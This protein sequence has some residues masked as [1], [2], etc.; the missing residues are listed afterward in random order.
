MKLSKKSYSKVASFAFA[1]L[2]TQMIKETLIKQLELMF[3]ITYHF[4][5]FLKNMI[6][7]TNKVTFWKQGSSFSCLFVSFLLASTFLLYIGYYFRT[8]T[9]T[10]AGV[11]I[12]IA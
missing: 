9:S 7:Q 1:E 11:L 5:E 2:M 6:L 3:K 4:K 12:L 8:V 10:S